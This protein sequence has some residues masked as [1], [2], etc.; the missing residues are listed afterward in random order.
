R[1]L[2]IR[3]E[4]EPAR[5]WRRLLIGW[6]SCPGDRDLL[7]P[8]WKVNSSGTRAD[9]KSV[10]GASLGGRDLCLPPWILNLAGLGTALKV[11]RAGRRGGRH[12]RYPPSPSGEMVNAVA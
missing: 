8:L 3:D 11:D 9:S 12:L 5:R 7:S 10:R 6:G 2:C 4:R 1:R